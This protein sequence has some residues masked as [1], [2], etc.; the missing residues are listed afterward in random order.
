VFKG[1]AH[2]LREAVTLDPR[3]TDVPSVKGRL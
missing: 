1:L 2:A 3:V